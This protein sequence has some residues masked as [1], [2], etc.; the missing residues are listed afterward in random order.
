MKWVNHV[1]VVRA[2]TDV[3]YVRLVPLTIIGA[4]ESEPLRWTGCPVAV[5][6]RFSMTGP[7]ITRAA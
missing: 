1:L 6:H 3:Y 7:D 4:T 5:G 2:V